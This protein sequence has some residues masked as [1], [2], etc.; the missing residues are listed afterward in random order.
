M[1]VDMKN[2]KRQLNFIILITSAETSCSFHHFHFEIDRLFKH[3]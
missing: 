3:H 1:V 2:F